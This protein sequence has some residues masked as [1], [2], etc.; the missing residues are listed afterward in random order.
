MAQSVLDALTNNYIFSAD[1]SLHGVIETETELIAEAAS[2]LVLL[3][4]NNTVNPR[5]MRMTPLHV[6]EIM[7][8]T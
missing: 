6:F 7:N 1:Q 8:N 5:G 3:E 4:P 2:A